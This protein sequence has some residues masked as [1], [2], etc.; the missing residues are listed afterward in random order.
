MSIKIL[1][2]EELV[3]ADAEKGVPGFIYTGASLC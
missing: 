2:N 3:P 1:R